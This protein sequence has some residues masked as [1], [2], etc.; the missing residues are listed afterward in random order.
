[1][2]ANIIKLD[3]GLIRVKQQYIDNRF[4]KGALIPEDI[5]W[6]NGDSEGYI[7][8]PEHR[9]DEMEN[10]RDEYLK[11]EKALF[12]CAKLNNQGIAFEKEGEIEKAIKIYEKNISSSNP[13]PAHHSYD[14]LLVL[15]RRLKDYEKEKRVCE[16]AVSLFE[17]EE[18]YKSRLVKI[19]AL[20]EKNK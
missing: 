15:Y 8:I 18:K 5:F 1:M 19:N 12:N 11:K 6:M 14:R 13:Y 7:T 17:T 16:L 4:M 20:I 2:K 10:K 3:N 9:L